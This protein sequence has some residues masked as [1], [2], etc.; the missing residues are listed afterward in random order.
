MAQG[1]LSC[2]LISG[3]QYSTP[4]NDNIGTCVQVG[5]CNE[6]ITL[7]IRSRIQTIFDYR[8]G[9]AAIIGRADNKKV[10]FR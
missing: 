2:T 9:L 1:A 8:R 6:Y 10:I 7:S 4:Y 3:A 5:K